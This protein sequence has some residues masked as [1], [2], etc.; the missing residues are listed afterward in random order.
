MKTSKAIL[1]GV[2]G[3]AAMSVLMAMGRAMGMKVM[4]EQ[5]LGT[6]T[7]MMPSP[8]TFAIGLGIHLMMGAAFGWVYGWAF[9]HLVHRGHWSTGALLAIPHVIVVGL[10]MGLV[11]TVH[12]LM[13]SPMPPPGLFMSHLGA[14]GVVA[15]I[16]L[17]VSSARSWA[18]CTARLANRG[19]RAQARVG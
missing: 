12:P 11:P 8:T 6:M 18:A 1:G 17:H 3:A 2:L 9:E 10:M 13:P 7:G 5:M 4:L 16:M 15:M 19:E 14:M